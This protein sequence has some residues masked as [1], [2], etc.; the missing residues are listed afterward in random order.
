MS[1]PI[2]DRTNR[3]S[4]FTVVELA[5]VIAVVS[6]MATLSFVGY[7]NVQKQ[8]RDKQRAA[9]AVVIAESLEKYY[10]QHG[11]YPNVAS[12]TATNADSVKQLLGITNIDS[13]V[14]ANVPGSSTVNAWKTGTASATN[15]LTYSPDTDPNAAC[16]TG[17]AGTSVCADYKIQYYQEKTDT[18]ETIYSR[19]KAVAATT[20][21]PPTAPTITAPTT[22][23]MSVALNG[24]VVT[25]T[26]SAT[27]CD[28]GTIL[29]YTFRSRTNDGTWS[30]Y[31]AWGTSNTTSS[32]TVAQGTKYG[33]QAKARCLAGDFP[34]AE[35][36]SVEGT[37]IHP[38]NTP[39]AP[40]LAVTPAA[41]NDSATWS[42]PAVACPA[43]TTAQYVTQFYRDDATGWRAYNFAA[44]QT[45]TSVVYA[46]NYEGYDHRARAQARC[47]SGFANSSWSADSNSPAFIS[48]VTA[49]G[50]AT[51]FRWS[52]YNGQPL[53]TWTESSCGL[54]TQQERRYWS[55]IEDIQYFADGTQTTGGGTT[56]IFNSTRA[57]ANV[58]EQWK[59]TA[60]VTTSQ[61]EMTIVNQKGFTSTASQGAGWIAYTGQPYTNSHDTK[62]VKAV[63]QLRCMNTTTGRN[64]QGNYVISAMFYR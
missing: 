27:S 2:I 53:F 58:F 19:H 50:I 61:L 22:P 55:Y 12:V 3:K 23:T 38:I 45:A 40:V 31:T 62:A 42:W 11:E 32:G 16:A 37:Y 8:S 63:V 18:F 6:I 57:G 17:A 49:P 34:S 14:V 60:P 15:K 35:M 43:G 33:F 51:N 39:A 64:A 29:Q 20:P 9:S 4:G 24:S 21:P 10:A 54:G 44:P 56:D 59:N 26:T 47:V 13:L 1:M 25:A 7:S 30:S 36:T 52:T 46:T 41:D 28:T 48:P 5:V